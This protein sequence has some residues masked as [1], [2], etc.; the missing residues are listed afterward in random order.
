MKD[1]RST[2]AVWKYFECLSSELAQCCLCR[3]NYSRKGRGTTSLKS[4]LRS[5]HKEQYRDLLDFEDQ[6]MKWKEEMAREASLAA[7]TSSSSSIRSTVDTETL[8]LQRSEK[9]SSEIQASLVLPSSSPPS[10]SSSRSPS[11]P[12]S[13]LSRPPSPPFTA[14]ALVKQ[15]PPPSSLDDFSEFVKVESWDGGIF[16]EA[17]L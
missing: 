15:E 3:K 7:P 1:S 2:S 16:Y 8:R 11:P 14:P 6:R 4:H 5:M 12:S 10:S 13:S 17:K 9:E